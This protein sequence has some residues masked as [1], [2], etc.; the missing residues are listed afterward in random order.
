MKSL[1]NFSLALSRSVR[2][3]VGVAAAFLAMLAGGHAMAATANPP[4]VPPL[5]LQQVVQQMVA[6]NAE[7][8]Q[9]L[10]QYRSR[11]AYS[12]TYQGFPSGLHAEMVVDVTYIAPDTKTFRIVSQSGPSLLV[13]QVLKRLLK[14]EAGAQLPQNRRRVDLTPQNYTFSHLL[15]QPSADGCSYSLTVD[16]V[17]RSKLLYRGQIWLNEHD[18]AVCKIEAE[19]ARNPS[20]WIASTHISHSYEKIGEFW[21]PR[22]NK[23]VSKMRFGGTATLRIA[24]QDYQLPPQPA[25]AVTTAAK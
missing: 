6:R 16:P 4:A 18:F 24:Y 15:Y 19:P 1:K 25:S 14:T 8:A 5:N 9:A 2:R 13:D 3:G 20:F 22:R 17:T 21:L 12:L 7:R 11:R 10:K 23:T